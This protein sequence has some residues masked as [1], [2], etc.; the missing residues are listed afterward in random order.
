[1]TAGMDVAVL[2]SPSAGRGRATALGDEVL[3]E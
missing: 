3:D 1:V 2:V